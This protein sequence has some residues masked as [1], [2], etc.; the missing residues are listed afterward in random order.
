MARTRTLAQLRSDVVDRADETDG[1]S[2]GRYTSVR[3]NRYINQAIQKYRAIV[4]GS[5]ANDFFMKRTGLLT[6]D[7]STTR[8]AAG[9]S[10]NMYIPR[11][12]DFSVLIGIDVYISGSGGQI[13]SLQPYDSVER[14]MFREDPTFLATNSIGQPVYY[15]LG[16]TNNTGIGL[17]QLLPYTGGAYQYEIFYVP[18]F[19]DLSS[20]SDT[21]DGVAGF[22]EYVVDCAALMC[23]QKE[24]N[25]SALYSSIAADV[26]E[27]EKSMAFKIATMGGVTRRM[28]TRGRRIDN[29]R[30]VRGNWWGS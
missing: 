25:V 10:P 1:G 2:G 13:T 12:T 29:R 9:W 5:G 26:K 16:G 22:E 27:M 18:L 3:L 28:D 17:I 19:T 8:D 11:P 6:M 20:D 15:R 30:Y 7:P 21:F 4:N 14:N 24:G 23:L